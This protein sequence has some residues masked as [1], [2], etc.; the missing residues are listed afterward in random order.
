MGK[1]L[2]LVTIVNAMMLAQTSEVMIRAQWSS[3]ELK[4]I[5]GSSLHFT[6]QQAEA[7]R[8]EVNRCNRVYVSTAR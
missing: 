2:T 4:L 1:A 5:T 7:I 8:A 6:A 3:E